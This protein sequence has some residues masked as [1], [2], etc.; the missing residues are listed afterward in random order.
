VNVAT[1][2]GYINEIKIQYSLNQLKCMKKYRIEGC[3]IRC[4]MKKILFIMKLTILAIFFGLGS[5]S[6]SPTYSQIK[7][8]TL[9]LEGATLSDLFKQIENQSEFVFIYKSEAVNLN[10]KVNVKVEEVTVDKVLENVLKDSD[11]KF[12]I[13]N[14]QI[15]LTPEHAAPLKK[16]EKIT[17]EEIQQPQKKTISGVVKDSKGEPLPGAAISIKGTTIG[18]ISD[19]DGKFTLT[20]PATTLNFTV[21]FVGMTTREIAIG[22]QTNFTITLQDMNQVIN[23]VVV[24]GYGTQKKESVVGAIATTTAESLKRSGS[25]V[26]LGQALTGQLAGVTT[27]QSTGEPGNDDPRILIRAQGTWNNSQPLIL[28]D[29]VERKMNDIDISEVESVSVLKDASATAVFGVKGSEG[30]ILITTKRGRLGKPQLTVDANITMKALSKTPD[31]LDSYDSYLMANSAIER[32]LP[33]TEAYWSKV[34]PM[35]KVDLY[36]N[37]AGFDRN[38]YIPG[39]PYKYWE[40]FPNVDWRKE[41]LKPFSL[42]NRV[43]INVTGGTDFAKYFGSLSYTH[44]ADLMNSGQNTGMPYKSQWAYDRFNFRTN[45]DFNITKMTVFSV[46]LSG[47]VGTKMESFNA[48]NDQN[49]GF[50]EAFYNNSP[51]NFIP[52]WSDGLWGYTELANQNNSVEAINNMGL[53]KIIRTQVSSDFKLTQQLDFITKGL[54]V[55]ASLSYDTRFYT[56]GGIFDR[57]GGAGARWVDPNIIFM[58]PG[59]NWQ[60]FTYGTN[61]AAGLLDYDWIPQP[62]W[63]LPESFG[64]FQGDGL[65][66]YG[67]PY[68]TPYRRLYYQGKVDW[69]RKFNKQN[70]A[71]TGVVNREEYAEGSEFPRYREDWVGRLTYDYDGRYFFEGNGAYNG[72]EKFARKNRFGFFPS[73]AVGWMISNEKWMKR[74]WLDK[75]KVR[76]SIGQVGNDNFNAPRWAYQTILAI[77]DNRTNFG[78]PDNAESPYAQYIEAVIGNPNLKWETS[79]KQ[80][81][82]FELAVLKNLINLNV[83]YYLDDRSDIFLSAGQRNI[84]AFLGASPVSANLG[85]THTEGYEIE[86]KLQKT[87]GKVGLWSNMAFTHA[88]DKVLY[89]E[90][91]TGLPK[92]QQNAGFQIDQTRSQI[93]NGFV[94]NWN[95]V[96]GTTAFASNK[97]YLQPGDL[98]IVDFNSDGVIDYNDDAP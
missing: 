20:F 3:G 71:F 78:T 95:D 79:Q 87:F 2:T 38:S 41:M 68:G 22:N 48:P 40:V 89:M 81:Y 25:P 66:Y 8:I 82:G 90:D 46:N 17:R 69:A 91:A 67:N 28:V 92:Y 43:N 63:H 65:D 49:T 10:K 16:E 35:S 24:I 61:R 30:V 76:Y 11:L 32:E 58:K 47:Y 44:D 85:K 29:G 37:H 6:A 55:S 94:N 77:D 23:E 59:Q 15:I 83:E 45:V 26:N 64:S 53:E 98:S 86:L 97:D 75:L 56:S 27:I 57:G 54:S 60:D 12:E 5:L 73:V 72:S 51:A 1:F 62:V 70:V 88:K 21:S 7:K 19:I 34:M 36:R 33:N 74:D 39:T 84:P 50:W 18:T 93:Q 42:S 4:R 96:Y 14:K 80:N 13:N 52:R 31:K 9:N